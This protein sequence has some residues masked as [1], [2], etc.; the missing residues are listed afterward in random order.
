MLLITLDTLRADHVSCYGPSPVTTPNLDSVARRGARVARA[1]T[2]I[3]L[4]TP[5][6]ATI[7]TGLYPSAHGVRNNGRFRLPQEVTTVAEVLKAANVRTA[8][9]VASFT[10]L[11]VFGLNQGFESYDDDLGNDAMGEPRNRRPANEVVDRASQ[12]LTTNGGAPFLLWV[13]LY[14][15]HFPYE[16]P[17][18]YGAR[19]PGD[20]YSAAVAF[21]DDQV[22][23]LIEVLDRTG[24]GA[25]TVVV[26][27]ADHGEGLKSHGEDH[28]GLLLYEEALRVP[29]LI[30]APGRIGPG[31]VIGELAS[32]VDVLPTALGLLGKPVPTGV[33]GRDL[34]SPSSARNPRRRVYAETLF[35]YEELRWSALYALREDDLKYVKGPRGELFDLAADPAEQHDLATQRPQD[36]ARLDAALVEMAGSIA[37]RDRLAR[38]A[39]LTPADPDAI[40]RLSGLGYIAGGSAADASTVLPALGGR[41]PRDGMD[42]YYGLHDAEALQRAKRTREALEQLDRLRRVDPGNPQVLLRSAS[43][44]ESAHDLARAEAVYRELL[45]RHPDFYLG[46]RYLSHLLVEEHRHRDAR[47]LWL[48]LGERIPGYVEVPLRLAEVEIAAGMPHEAAA[49]LG[50]YLRAHAEDAEGWE[51]LGRA[52]AATG[53]NN[54]ALR[55]FQSCLRLRPTSRNAAQGAVK[56]LVALGH[57]SEARQLLDELS[58]RAPQD[59]LLMSLRAGLR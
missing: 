5:A 13:H 25:R 36:A 15:P 23:R 14:D 50:P 27:V 20:P 52:L 2:P 6:H 10:T 49:R 33:Q 19:F 53:Q 42:I 39:G 8:A 37:N 46:Y 16:S 59:P 24:A 1:W 3:P 30:A 40:E 32:T 47:A 4:T 44:W 7:L 58:A 48:D 12:W 41:N 26:A 22:G 54:D 38:A 9:F 21:T 55:A 29:F 45:R 28:H 43:C 18:A 56:L 51:L 34:L 11:G 31:T 17:A 35:P 57:R